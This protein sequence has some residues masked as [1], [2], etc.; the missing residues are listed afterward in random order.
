MLPPGLQKRHY[1]SAFVRMSLF[2]Q[3]SNQHIKTNR[4]ACRL[5]CK[6]QYSYSISACFKLPIVPDIRI[7]VS[8][9]LLSPAR[10]MPGSFLDKVTA[11]STQILYNI[12]LTFDVI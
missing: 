10:Q 12:I 11:A 6:A 8:V 2:S 5:T 9:V 4:R 7:E 3:K 1:E